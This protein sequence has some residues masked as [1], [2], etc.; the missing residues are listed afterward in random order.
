MN[1][2]NSLAFWCDKNQRPQDVSS[3]S[4]PEKI[5]GIAVGAVA[6]IGFIAVAVLVVRKR[7]KI[8]LRGKRYEEIRNE[9]EYESNVDIEQQ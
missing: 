9:A 7:K 2:W 6:L 1:W 8:L 4:S 3:P 5:V